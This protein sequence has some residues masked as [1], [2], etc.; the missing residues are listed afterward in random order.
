MPVASKRTPPSRRKPSMPA[1]SVTMWKFTV[2]RPRATANLTS[3]AT[4][5]PAISTT[6]ASARRGS[7]LP[8][9]T[10][11]ARTGSSITSRRSMSASLQQRGQALRGNVDPVGAVVG[12]VAQL[13]EQLLHLGER[14]QARHVVERLVDAAARAR[15]GVCGEKSLARVVLPGLERGAEPLDAGLGALAHPRR[16]ARVAERAQH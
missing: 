6:S 1:R 15:R 14:E 9:C 11:K 7:R 10:R 4:I 13:V 2:R 3:L 5:H 8:T 12:F 16:A